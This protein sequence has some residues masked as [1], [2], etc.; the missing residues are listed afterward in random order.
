MAENL[1]IEDACA[2]TIARITFSNGGRRPSISLVPFGLEIIHRG[3]QLGA[4]TPLHPK[5]GGAKKQSEIYK[6]IINSYLAM[7]PL[8]FT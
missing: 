1:T 2:S 6:T 5:G 3:K 7:H 8:P 4:F